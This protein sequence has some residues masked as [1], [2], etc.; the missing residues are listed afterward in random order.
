[1]PYNELPFA[2][3]SVG[4]IWFVFDFNSMHFPLKQRYKRQSENRSTSAPC[5][6]DNKKLMTGDRLQLTFVEGESISTLALS[7]EGKYRLLSCKQQQQ[8]EWKRCM[9]RAQWGRYFYWQ[10][11]S[12]TLPPGHILTLLLLF[13]R[14]YS[15]IECECTNVERESYKK[16]IMMSKC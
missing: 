1:M 8:Q 7:V 16:I 9:R 14:E 10:T 15:I 6:G 3:E 4:N 2:A 12:W 13:F 5:R 11:V